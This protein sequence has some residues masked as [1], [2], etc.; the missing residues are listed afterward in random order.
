V[1]FQVRRETRSCEAVQLPRAESRSR[2]KPLT[3]VPPKTDRVSSREG[4]MEND[5]KA[6]GEGC[7]AC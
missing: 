4:G 6:R 7:V 5:K 3:A 1:R 2:E